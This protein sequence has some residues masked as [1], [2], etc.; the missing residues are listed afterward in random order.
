MLCQTK[1]EIVRTSHT[2]IYHPIIPVL[3]MSAEKRKDYGELAENDDGELYWR[4]IT[5]SEEA[6]WRKFLAPVLSPGSDLYQSVQPTS[7]RRFVG[8]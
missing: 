2:L 8:R 4:A 7:R 1:S 3:I 5:G 6:E